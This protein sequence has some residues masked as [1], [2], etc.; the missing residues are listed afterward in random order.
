MG[1]IITGRRGGG[2]RH[3]KHRVDNRFPMEEFRVGNS[4]L[5][6]WRA[7]LGL[8]VETVRG[9]GGGG[10]SIVGAQESIRYRFQRY[11]LCYLDK[12]SKKKKKRRKGKKKKEG[13]A[14]A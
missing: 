12:G 1:R 4:K 6:S 13:N 9:M 11:R 3:D 10:M 2:S 8:T 7:S 14:R 5:I